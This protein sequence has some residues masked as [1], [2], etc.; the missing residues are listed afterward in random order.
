MQPTRLVINGE[1][2]RGKVPTK[3][4]INGESNTQ[5]KTEKIAVNGDVKQIVSM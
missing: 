4:V 2:K 5:K 1:N 3:R